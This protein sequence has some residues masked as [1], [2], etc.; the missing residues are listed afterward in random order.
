[1]RSLVIAAFATAAVVSG[2][3]ISS[4]PATAQDYPYCLQGRQQGYPGLCNFS[5]FQQCKAAA[6]GTSSDCGINPRVA[7]GA[8]Q[9]YA[10][11]YYHSRTQW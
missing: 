1:M 10:G 11:R 3:S 4:T 5:T 8:Q 2:L 9:L 6:S 7:Y